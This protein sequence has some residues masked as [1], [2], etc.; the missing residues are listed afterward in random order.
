MYSA[1][2][3]RCA[4]TWIVVL[5]AE[6][7]TTFWEIIEELV[8]ESSKPVTLQDRSSCS[9]AEDALRKGT[10]SVAV[11]NEKGRSAV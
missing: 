8:S 2:L 4:Q 6:T 11:A 5:G 7:R 10:R 9:L 3:D 1:L